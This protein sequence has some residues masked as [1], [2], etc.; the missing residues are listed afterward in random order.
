VGILSLSH[1][2][3]A[4]HLS[5]SLWDDFPSFATQANL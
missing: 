5:T 4:G 2:R 1:F 3:G